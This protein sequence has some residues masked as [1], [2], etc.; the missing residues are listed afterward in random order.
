MP[1]CG[2]IRCALN[3]WHILL[4]PPLTAWAFLQPRFCRPQHPCL[5]FPFAFRLHF[6]DTC[7]RV[8]AQVCAPFLPPPGWNSEESKGDVEAPVLPSASNSSDRNATCGTG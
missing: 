3:L 6:A 1:P 2:Q 7:A 4:T 5:E 8:R